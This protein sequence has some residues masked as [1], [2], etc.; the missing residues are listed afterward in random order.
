MRHALLANDKSERSIRRG[1]KTMQAFKHIIPSNHTFTLN[2]PKLLGVYAGVIFTFYQA[3][4]M[5][6]VCSCFFG[7]Y[8]DLRVAGITPKQRRGSSS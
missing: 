1:K 2:L 8:R 7:D 3:I 4:A 6:F 5:E